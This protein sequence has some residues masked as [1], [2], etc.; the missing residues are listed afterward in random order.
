MK[1]T[2]AKILVGLSVIAFSQ[3]VFAETRLTLSSWMPS[4]HPMA[5]EMIFPWAKE[6]AEG[7]VTVDILAKALGHP[8]IHYDIARDGLAAINRQ[9]PLRGFKV[10]VKLPR[11]MLRAPKL[12][13]LRFIR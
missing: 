9:S 11:S 1:R 12:S 13:P 4:Q 8:K 7:R 3:S 2:V 5:A 10:F 6:V